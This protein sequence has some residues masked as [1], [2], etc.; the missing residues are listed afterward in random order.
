MRGNRKARELDEK[1]PVQIPE[2]SERTLASFL[3][4]EKKDAVS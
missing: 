3:I 2:T 1:T 4:G